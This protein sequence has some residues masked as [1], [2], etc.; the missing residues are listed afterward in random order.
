MAGIHEVVDSVG[1]AVQV[2]RRQEPHDRVGEVLRERRGAELVAHHLERLAGIAGAVGG[3][4]DLLR[5]VVARWTEQP[6]RADDR[7]APGAGMEGL[8]RSPLARQLRR[9]V[10]IDRVR[11]LVRRVAEPVGSG[12]AEHLVGAHLDQLDAGRGRGTRQHTDCLAVAA[13]R[14]LRVACAAVDIRPGRRVD[15]HLGPV[16][17]R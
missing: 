3:R 6:G 12:S 2:A 14:Q 7:Q 16:T 8:G 10:R 1:F 17:R 9:A 4:D 13:Q 5:E 15:D 11:L